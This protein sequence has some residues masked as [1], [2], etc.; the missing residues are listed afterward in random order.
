MRPSSAFGL[1][2]PA[3]ARLT[4]SLR[5][6]LTVLLLSLA[7]GGC[8]GSGSTGSSSTGTDLVIHASPAKADVDAGGTFTVD[9]YAT[10]T[11][12]SSALSFSLQGVGALVVTGPSLFGEYSVLYTAPGSPTS[13][14]G[15]SL[16]G[17]SATITVTAKADSSKTLAIPV[18][19]HDN[20]DFPAPTPTPAFVGKPYTYTFT[21]SGGTGT[22]TYSLIAASGALP[23]GLTLSSAGVLSGT[24]TTMGT[25]SFLVVAVDQPT[26]PVGIGRTIS[27]QV[28]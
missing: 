25:Y 11:A 6:A 15:T 13:A 18:T 19:L 9:A 4:S 17:T 2:T 16:A 10:V 23:A 8:G 28:S 20:I 22:F 21:A 27:L 26:N 3:F 1:I 24:P 5:P 12:A 14:N 7:L